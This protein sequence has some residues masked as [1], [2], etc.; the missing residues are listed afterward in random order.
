MCLIILRT[1][2]EVSILSLDCDVCHLIATP[3]TTFSLLSGDNVKN[4]KRWH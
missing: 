1:T 2:G 3:R 4:V